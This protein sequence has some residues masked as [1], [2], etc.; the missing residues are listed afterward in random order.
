MSRI[1]LLKFGV[2]LKYILKYIKF[3]DFI[4]VYKD[5]NKL[6]RRDINAYEH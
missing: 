4:W 3:C 5:S 1:P 6:D 2:R